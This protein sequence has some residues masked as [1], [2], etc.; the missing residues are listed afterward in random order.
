VAAAVAPSSSDGIINIRN[1][2]TITINSSVTADQVVVDAGGILSLTSVLTLN[3]GTGTDLLVNGDMQVLS[4]T[5]GWY[6]YS[7]DC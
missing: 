3:D 7:N 5:V 1:T 6:R 2:N 4:G